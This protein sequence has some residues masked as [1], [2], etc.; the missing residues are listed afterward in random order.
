MEKLIVLMF[1]VMNQLRSLMIVNI[2]SVCVTCVVGVGFD[3][4]AKVLILLIMITVVVTTPVRIAFMVSIMVLLVMMGVMGLLLMS[5]LV[6][7]LAMVVI[8][9]SMLSGPLRIEGRNIMGLS[10]MSVSVLVHNWNLVV[11]MM[12]SLEVTIIFV[13]HMK[14]GLMVR[15][16]RSFV[17]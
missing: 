5:L 16:N 9:V 1:N 2:M 7:V 4:M 14:R 12:G 11:L 10:C 6:Q 3:I 13:L 8:K 17:R 15:I